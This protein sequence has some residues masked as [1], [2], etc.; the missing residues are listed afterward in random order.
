MR[1][2]EVRGA[3][4]VIVISAKRLLRLPREL[5]RNCYSVHNN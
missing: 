5:I 4:E 3:R 1:R 2:T